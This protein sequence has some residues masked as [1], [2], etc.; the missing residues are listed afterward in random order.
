MHQILIHI[1]EQQKDALFKRRKN[2]KVPVA[3]QIRE[4]IDNYIKE[5]GK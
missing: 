4:A 1:T 5:V 2:T 3:A